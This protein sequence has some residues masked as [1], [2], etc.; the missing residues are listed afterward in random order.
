[1]YCV[2]ATGIVNAE[3]LSWLRP[4]SAFINGGRGKHVVES[5]LLAALD[6]QQVDNIAEAGRTVVAQ[7]Q[8]PS[9]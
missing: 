9:A 6:S 1:V 8:E 4:G 2:C 7:Q 5:D 3:L